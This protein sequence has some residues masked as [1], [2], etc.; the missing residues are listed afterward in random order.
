M[1]QRPSRTKPASQS[2]LDTMR[3]SLNDLARGQ[4]DDLS[5]FLADLNVAIEKA[6][7]EKK[8]QPAQS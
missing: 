5:G 1:D 4:W 7:N 6:E 3:A 2:P 8:A